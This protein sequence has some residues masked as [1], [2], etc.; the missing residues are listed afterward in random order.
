VS[1]KNHPHPRRWHL[2]AAL[3]AD[4]RLA[5]AMIIG[6][7]LYGLLAWLD[8]PVFPCPW[9]NVTGLPCPGCGMTRSTFSLLHGRVLESLNYNALTGII[10]LFWLIIVIGITIPARYRNIWI[11]KIGQWEQ[12]SKWALWFAG[13]VAIYTLTRWLN[14]L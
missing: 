10:L 12:R 3:L 8:I 9:K 14:F 6:T 13:I 4:M 2:I 5:R 7:A 11:E 1:E